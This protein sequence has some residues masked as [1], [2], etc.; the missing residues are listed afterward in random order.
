[1]NSCISVKEI[2]E[3]P[4]WVIN[5]KDGSEYIGECIDLSGSL[6]VRQNLKKR[7]I[8]NGGVYAVRKSFFE[9]NKKIRDDK[10]T[11][12]HEMSKIKSLDIDDE[13]DFIICESLVKS[14][15]I[16]PE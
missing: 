15:I 4:E 3:Y 1:M 12:V 5:K 8:A 14:G 2:T 11:L 10:N 6:S 7:W 16:H 13:Y 9:K